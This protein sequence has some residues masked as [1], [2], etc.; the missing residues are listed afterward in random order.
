MLK[1]IKDATE[2]ILDLNFTMQAMVITDGEG[3]TI[4]PVVSSDNDFFIDKTRTKILSVQ[5]IVRSQDWQVAYNEINNVHELWVN[6]ELGLEE[7]SKI[8][9]T[10]NPVFVELDERGFYV[11]TSIY[12]FEIEEMNANG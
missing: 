7:I 9:C 10:N 6:N 11:Y 8:T 3:A 1:Q 2:S 5:Y 4:R 12:N